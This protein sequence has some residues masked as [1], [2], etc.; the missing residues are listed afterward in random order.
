[1]TAHMTN[2]CPIRRLAPALTFAFGQFLL[3]YQ[4]AKADFAYV[5]NALAGT[6]LRFDL[7]NGSQSMEVVPA[8]E[9]LQY[10]SGLAFDQTN[11]LN[12]ANYSTGVIS[13][14]TLMGTALTPLATMAAPGP[15][16]IAFNSLG[17]AFVSDADRNQVWKFPAN[18]AGFVW[19]NTGLAN[20]V[21]ITCD[22]SDNVYVSSSGGDTITR[23][24]PQGSGSVF[25]LT[26]PHPRGLAFDGSGYLYA[27]I[28]G[29]NTVQR[30]APDG[31]GSVF[32][33][34]LLSL[35]Q[36]LAFDS[37]GNIYVTN[38][39]SDTISRFT[40]S[41]SGSQ[42]AGAA[43]GL[44]GPWGI[45]IVPEPATLSWLGA[46]LIVGAMSLYRRRRKAP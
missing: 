32:A 41:G 27:A 40:P 46:V 43:Q 1:M 15:H 28:S 16:C 30:F 39:D 10:P 24:T 19:A 22:S 9:G 13:R 29:N 6:V 7:S 35:P 21:G 44:N 26:G 38:F 37:L 23:F 45:A 31:A 17:D 12:V 20:P 3:A 25:A 33:S 4:V 34:T 8:S 2:A 36:S 5:S 18:G 14:F 42:F 11:N